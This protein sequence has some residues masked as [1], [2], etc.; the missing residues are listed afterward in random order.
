M[1][2]PKACV[3]TNDTLMTPREQESVL[4]VLGRAGTKIGRGAGTK[5]GGE[6]GTK[7]G[8]GAGTKIGRGAG[9]K[10][11]GGAGGGVDMKIEEGLA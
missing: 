4:G 6:A 1:Q 2:T 9:A 3:L 8:G 11:G 7:I 10:I 5:I